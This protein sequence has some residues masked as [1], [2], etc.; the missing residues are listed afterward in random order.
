V[1]GRCDAI[2]TSGWS[3]RSNA[4]STISSPLRCVRHVR[5]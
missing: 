3:R 4:K 2:L 5:R 1:M